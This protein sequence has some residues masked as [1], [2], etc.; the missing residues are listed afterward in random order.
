[1]WIDE[2]GKNS[3]PKKPEEGKSGK[4]RGERKRGKK[5]GKCGGIR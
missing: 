2:D 3:I 4:R 1:V 5:A